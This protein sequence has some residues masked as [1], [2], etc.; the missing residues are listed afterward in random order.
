MSGCSRPPSLRAWRSRA[1]TDPYR[2]RRC[3]ASVAAGAVAMALLWPCVA[4]VR[5]TT[6]HD[7]YAAVKL[8]IAEA[9]I[10][11]GFNSFEP[12]RYRAADGTSFAITRGGLVL[13]GELNL[14]VADCAEAH[15]SDR[16]RGTADQVAAVDSA[17]YDGTAEF[18]RARKGDRL[19]S[20][21]RTGRHCCADSIGGVLLQRLGENHKKYPFNQYGYEN[22]LAAIE[23]ASASRWTVASELR[24]GRRAVR[25]T[26]GRSG[27]RTVEHARRSNIH[28]GTSSAGLCGLPASGQ[29]ATAIAV[30][31][32]SRP[33]I[34]SHP[35]DG[36]NS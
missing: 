31:A 25:S 27:L 35:A 24:K 11:V 28:T 26:C 22:G 2:W 15:R 20:G 29:R 9:M 1:M 33:T 19:V 21:R 5:G 34:T 17:R 32:T 3:A 18:G 6:A 8:T 7:W 4:L 36:C 14:D 12:T 23:Q 30:L 13:Y 10:A 16:V